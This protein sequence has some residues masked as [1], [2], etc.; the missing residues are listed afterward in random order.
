MSPEQARGSPAD[1]RSDQFALGVMLYEMTTATHP[2]KRDTAVQTLSAIITDE[3]PD[4][5]GLNPA[6]PV[7]LR[8]LIRRLLAKNPRER[9]AHT[10]DLAAD[11]R[12]IR[13]YQAEATSAVAA[14]AAPRRR[15]W[16]P[17]GAVAVLVAGSAFLAGL[18]LA[19]GESSVLFDRITPFVT[20]GVYQGSPAWS[21]DGKSLAYEAEV[22]G[23]IQIFT[24][25][26][27][28]AVGS[29]VTNSKF[30]CYDPIWSA[31]GRYIYYTSLAQ[32][33]DA[34]WK[35]SPAGGSPQRIVENAVRSAIARN[36]T[37][38]FLK[39]DGTRQ[40]LWLAPA[41]EQGAR[42]YDVGPL[43]GR[44]FSNGRLRFT[45]NGSKLLAWLFPVGEYPNPGFW[46]IRMPDG[47]ARRVMESLP[48]RSYRVP[49]F[50]W[51]SD[52]RHVV[53]TRA[54]GPTPG[55][56]LWVADTMTD[57]IRPLR[58]PSATRTRRGCHRTDERLFSHP[59]RR[60]SIWSRC[61]STAGRC[62]PS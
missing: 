50:G 42:Q 38:A 21:P 12:T 55:T 46:E 39:S 14:A 41:P 26:L 32:D 15:R 52:N 54:D 8:W 53:L 22:D 29:Q 28:S 11:L 3:P 44:Q 30:D 49:L 35:V 9:F 37:L 10:A 2:F 4:P 51:L 7:P 57:F 45:E 5:A 13:D 25:A 6:L 20:D 17:W 58:Q 62:G 23:V 40:T 48:Q 24:R 27:G 36:G 61:R 56:H 16:L 60:I 31:D 47:E 18:S 19:S 1:F 43:K 33:R 34:L 59:R